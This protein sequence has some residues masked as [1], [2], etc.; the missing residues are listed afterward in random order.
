MATPDEVEKSAPLHAAS[1][2]ATKA[3]AAHLGLTIQDVENWLQQSKNPPPK[4]LLSW[5]CRWDLVNRPHHRRR[6]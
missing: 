2:E 4:V 6:T 5:I 1:E 3:L